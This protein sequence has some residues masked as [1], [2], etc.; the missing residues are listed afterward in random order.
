MKLWNIRHEIIFTVKT[1]SSPELEKQ[2]IYETNCRD[3]AKQI[4]INLDR[5]VLCPENLTGTCDTDCKYGH[6]ANS[7]EC[8]GQTCHCNY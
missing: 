7:G 1:C 3:A 6:D 5:N 8:V 2:N 4:T